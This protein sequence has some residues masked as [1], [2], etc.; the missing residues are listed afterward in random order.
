[1]VDPLT[2]A[3]EAGVERP[4]ARDERQDAVTSGAATGTNGKARRPL[5]R[6]YALIVPLFL[7]AAVINSLSTIYDLHRAGKAPPTWEPVSWELTSILAIFVAVPIL[8]AVARLAP[9]GCG[10]LRILAFNALAT[11]P[12]S[13]VHTGGM[14]GLRT[15]IYRLAGE[16]YR[17]AASDFLYEYRKDLLTYL[18]LYGIFWITSRAA[19]P[20]PA[21]ET[22]RQPPPA[23]PVFTIVDGGRTHRATPGEILA[24]RAAGNYVEF[25]LAGGE[26]PLMRGSLQEMQ[27]KLAGHGFLRTHRS[28]VVNPRRVRQLT[29]QGSGDFLLTLDSGDEAPLSRRFPEALS[30]LRK[31]EGAAEATPSFVA[32]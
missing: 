22:P 14:F 7:L 28:W 10:W 20:Q 26:R 31:K 32:K 6:A 25:H 23:D 1:M 3:G 21:A 30:S 13:L 17:F 2:T 15:L 24:L 8:P 27:E 29:A 16:H 11:L 4:P 19:A 5:L 12:F 18:I 9:P